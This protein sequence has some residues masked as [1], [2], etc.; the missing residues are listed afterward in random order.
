MKRPEVNANLRDAKWC[1]RLS[2]ACFVL[3]ALCIVGGIYTIALGFVFKGI[4]ALCSACNA[5]VAACSLG[6]SARVFEDAETR[7]RRW[8]EFP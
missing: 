1:R 2:I 6:K 4:V 8:G 7:E 3:A 5:G